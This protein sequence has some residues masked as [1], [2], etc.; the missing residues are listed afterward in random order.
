MAQS[1]AGLT[2]EIGASGLENKR[3]G[4]SYN[5]F[6]QAWR[7][8]QK[9]RTVEEMVANSPVIGALRLS[10]EMPIRDIDWFFTGPEEADPVGPV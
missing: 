2:R 7:G 9:V 4:Y 8:A 10:F 6:L 3:W 1:R 5:D